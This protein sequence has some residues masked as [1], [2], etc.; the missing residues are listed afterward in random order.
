MAFG[1]L[2]MGATKKEAAET[3]GED[4]EQRGQGYVEN[5]PRQQKRQTE[6]ESYP[7][8]GVV[9]VV[10]ESLSTFRTTANHLASEVDM[11]TATET[12]VFVAGWADYVVATGRLENRRA[13]VGARPRPIPQ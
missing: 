11:R 5:P 10:D 8:L 12:H 13:A 7:V 1:F 2:G 6:A 4:C 3:T 9:S